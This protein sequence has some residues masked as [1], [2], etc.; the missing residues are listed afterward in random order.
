MGSF[1][2]SATGYFD[3][4]RGVR[5]GDPLSPYLFI[6][7][8]EILATEVRNDEVIIGVNTGG[9]EVKQVLYA[10]DMTIFVKNKEYV[11][12]VKEIYTSLKKISGLRVNAEKLIL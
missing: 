6:L 9:I 7:A 3:I 5:Q 12:R 11:E 1:V 10:D 4:T 2:F 8:I